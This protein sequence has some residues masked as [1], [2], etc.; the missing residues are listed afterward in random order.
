MFS[1]KIKAFVLSLCILQF[2][3]SVLLAHPG[4]ID[5]N[6]GHSDSST[7][8]QIHTID[9]FKAETRSSG[10]YTTRSGYFATYTRGDLER[11]IKLVVQG[12]RAAIDE[13][14]DSG[15]AFILE[16]GLDV[17]LEEAKIFSGIVEIRLAGNSATVWTVIEAIIR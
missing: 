8:L 7:S 15:R 17:Y 9:T 4:N 2:V 13:F 1:R 14:I 6:E 16:G 11:L 10:K 5:Q 3:G 12:D